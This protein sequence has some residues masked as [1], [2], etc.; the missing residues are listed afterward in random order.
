MFPCHTVNVYLLSCVCPVYL[1]DQGF[2]R[3]ETRCP[4]INQSA[5]KLPKRRT[6][7]LPSNRLEGSLRVAGLVWVPVLPA[8]LLLYGVY[9]NTLW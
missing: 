8:E 7:S 5:Q 3:T 2:A 4:V 6:G 1:S 9:A